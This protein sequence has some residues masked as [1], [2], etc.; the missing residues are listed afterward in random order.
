MTLHDENSGL[1]SLPQAL[2]MESE[3][4]DGPLWVKRIPQNAGNGEA[5]QS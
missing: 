3:D 4:E 1:M 2:E 5:M